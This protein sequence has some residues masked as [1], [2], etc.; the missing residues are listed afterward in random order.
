[1]ESARAARLAQGL[2]QHIEDPATLDFL[3][4]VLSRPGRGAAEEVDHASS[5]T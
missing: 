2:P 3:A 5:S 4:D 1:V